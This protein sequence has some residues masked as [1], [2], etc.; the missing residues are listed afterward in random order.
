MTSFIKDFQAISFFGRPFQEL[1]RCF[2]LRSEQLLGQRVLECP[3]GP[4]SFV[5]EAIRRGVE[6]VGVDPLFY[7]SPDAL[8]QLAFSDFE[9]MF[10]RM[11][12][13]SDR[14]VAKTYASI[15]EAKRR[16]REGLELF[17]QDYAKAFASGRYRCGALP[18]LDFEDRSFDL[19]LCGHLFFIYSEALDLAFHRAAFRELCRLT[20][21]EIRIHPIVDGQS[22]RYPHL[23]DLLEL[24]DGL[25][26]ESEI[27]PVEHEFFKGT[28]ETLV[29]RRR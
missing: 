15:D 20:R 9:E 21:R 19:T 18:R 24:A 3:S 4:S 16:R 6:T 27:R 13:N 8:R 11:R 14:F 17:L 12:A 10:E 7:R 22:R 1:L 25:G 26:F 28:N 2:G 5:A 23:G 29:L